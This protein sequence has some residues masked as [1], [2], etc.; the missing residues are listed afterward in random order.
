MA[1]AK[2]KA[3]TVPQNREQAGAA[4]ARYAQLDRAVDRLEIQMNEEIAKIKEAYFQTALPIRIEAE[5]IE[6]AL[7][8]FCEANRDTLTNNRNTKTI[9]FGVGKTSWRSTPAKVTVNG[10]EEDLVDHIKRSE[11]PELK[12]FLRATFEIDKVQVLRNPDQ[13][14]KL[15]GVE[16]VRG[17]ETFEIKPDAAKIPE[18]AEAA[19]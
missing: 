2:A 11:D 5:E 6:A 16:I 7:Q 1:P 8:S 10:K 9:D 18:S 19:E 17:F 3:L 15:P 12:K 13:V 4:L 14:G